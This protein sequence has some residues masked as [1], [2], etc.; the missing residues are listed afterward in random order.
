MIFRL[1]NNWWNFDWIFLQC[2]LLTK[3]SIWPQTT[4][5]LLK[6]QTIYKTLI[7]LQVLWCEISLY[8]ILYVIYPTFSPIHTCIYIHMHTHSLG[9]TTSGSTVYTQSCH[10]AV[11]FRISISISFSILQHMW[12]QVWWQV[13]N[14][15][16]ILIPNPKCNPFQIDPV[17][18]GPDKNEEGC[19]N[20][21]LCVALN[22]YI[23]KDLWATIVTAE[24]FD[25][26]QCY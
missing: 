20:R 9:P 2:R 21:W 7:F 26:L 19:R 5:V 12:C 13:I 23:N 18:T 14:I 17:R 6:R 22:D 11:I 15:R 1:R 24:V 25:Y 16:Q 8:P 3:R 10:R 4:K